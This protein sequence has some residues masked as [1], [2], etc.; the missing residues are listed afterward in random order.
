[1]PLGQEPPQMLKQRLLY[2]GRKFDFDVNRLRLPNLLKETGNV[3]V[4]QAAL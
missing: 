1:M 2:R 3:S 4:I